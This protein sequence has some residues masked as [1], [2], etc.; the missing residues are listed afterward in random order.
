MR[1]PALRSR[2]QHCVGIVLCAA[3][4]VGGAPSESVKGRHAAILARVLSYELTLEERAGDSVQVAVVYRRDD[5]ISEANADEWLRGLAALGSVNVKDRPILSIKVP[6]LMNELN[7]AI[8]KGA[9]MLL[10]AE[11]LDTETP[12]IAQL[13]RSRRVLTAGN[14]PSYVHRDLTLCV[15]EEGDKTR[16]FIN[17]NAAQL[18]RIRFS[19]RLLNLA[20]VI[21]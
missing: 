6:Y 21:R 17:L 8:D 20:V 3:L 12:V 14:S 11:G 13:A 16:I 15:A 19:S 5:A 2:L 10:V 9:D 18:E 4:L 1:A 7:A